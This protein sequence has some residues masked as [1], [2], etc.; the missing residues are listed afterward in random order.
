M[1]SYA[2]GRQQASLSR[3]KYGNSIMKLNVVI[4]A[5][6]KGTRMR[7]SLPKVLH[8]LADKSLVE[9]VITTAHSLKAEKVIGIY[10]HGG[11]LV[12]KALSHLDVT[13]IEQEEQ[14]GT[15]HAVDQASHLIDEGLVLVLYG[16]VP[17]ITTSTLNA[18]IEISKKPNTM[19]LLTAILDDPTGYGRIVR[20]SDDSVQ[21]IVEQK[22]ASYDEL[23]IDEVNT[24]ILCAESKQL[25]KW[26]DSLE[27]NN[28]QG[29]YY[30]T[31]IIEMAVSDGVE[32]QTHTVSNLWEIE[33]VNSKIQL[34]MLERKHQLNIAN[35]LLIQGVTLKDPARIDVRGSLTVG[36]DVEIDINTIFEGD[37]TL[38]N[39][40]SIAANC[41]IKNSSIADNTKIQPNS[42]LEDSSIGEDCEIGPYARI[43]PE[44]VLLSNVKIGNFVEIKKANIANNSKVNHLSYIGDTN[45]GSNVNIGAGT[46]TCNYDGANKH[47]TEIGND[48][49]VG[50]SS[51]LV[52]PVKIGDGATIGAGSTITK[53]VPASELALSRSKQISTPGWKRP[54]KNKK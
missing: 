19:G 2:I 21:K 50:S 6:G 38:G 4:L 18:L 35:S 12:P 10:G 15:G 22:D 42:L 34:A 14:L 27:N 29:E 44:S 3:N 16:D 26:L 28:S 25:A 53:E 36:T 31:D 54:T 13:W 8:K 24:G 52:A 33:G 7:S 41:I 39:N 1:C 11:D 37:V 47:L 40:V 9:H 49:F 48:V 5:A 51:Q 17:L 32:V 43:R 23:T 46:I 20:S 30:L 45:M